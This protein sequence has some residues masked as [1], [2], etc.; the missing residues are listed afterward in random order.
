MSI[1]NNC[2][3]CHLKHNC[4]CEYLP[5][6]S[7]SAHLA[8]LMHNNEI[9]RKTNTGQ[10]LL[11]SIKQTS[12]HIWERK[13]PCVELERL[14]NDEKYQACL[15]FPSEDSQPIEPFIQ[16]GKTANKIPL[17]VI[18]DGT[19]QEAKKMRNKSP[20]LKSLPLIHLNP[21][22]LS[23]YK[24]RRNQDVNHLC[25]L[26]VGADI[27]RSLGQ[28]TQADNLT[29]FLTRYMAAFQADRSGHPLNY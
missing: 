22:Q 18:L 5:D 14:I 24:L 7:I 4:V 17:F 9:H 23:D 28:P 16:K 12:Q 27:I 2:P 21:T 19:W 8:L 29:H 10:W 26:E 6:V 15:L 1:L 11:K 3:T 25:T 20:W 13:A